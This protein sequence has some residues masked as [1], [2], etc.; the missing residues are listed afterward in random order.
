MQQE[1][2]LY[3]K[4][5]EESVTKNISK[6]LPALT[7][8]LSGFISL[9]VI[10]L[11]IGYL[12]FDAYLSEMNCSWI[13]KMSNMR[14]LYSRGILP[15]LSIIMLLTATIVDSI[16]SP[17]KG[18]QR[19]SFILNNYYWLVGLLIV[20][21]VI[22]SWL[23]RNEVFEIVVDFIFTLFF[24]TYILSFFRVVI[25]EGFSTYSTNSRHLIFM[26]LL[27]F[28]GFYLLPTKVG[29]IEA[30]MR[31]YKHNYSDYSVELD[32]SKQS[33][34][35]LMFLNEYAV[36]MNHTTP[37]SGLHLVKYEKIKKIFKTP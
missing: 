31:L 33:R 4:L 14:D 30:K 29:T 19:E 11:V 25:V 17:K 26:W 6:F 9:N 12:R 18:K 15:G 34:K 32:S 35:V 7:K 23:L 8:L 2:E 22:E 5:W 24:L 36:I 3:R 16:Q 37:D 1:N 13:L 27:L 28:F 20:I 10:V 21:S